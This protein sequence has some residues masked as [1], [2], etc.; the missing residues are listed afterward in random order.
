VKLIEEKAIAIEGN[1]MKATTLKTEKNLL[2]VDGVFIIRNVIPM[3]QLLEG[4]EMEEGSIKVDR[5]MAASIPG[6]FA[7]GDAVGKPYQIAKA[8]GEGTVA[9]LSA[10]KHIDRLNA[11]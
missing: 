10:V 1:E 8:V 5:N 4:I 3:G 6:V 9:A 7:C 11:K 2:E